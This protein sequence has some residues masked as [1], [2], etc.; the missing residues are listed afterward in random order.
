[1]KPMKRAAW[2]FLAALGTVLLPVLPAQG[3]PMPDGA[4][5][6]TMIA[7]ACSD[8]DTPPCH[9]QPAHGTPACVVCCVTC[10]LAVVPD[11]ETMPAPLSLVTQLDH[12][13]EKGLARTEPPPLPPP[14][15][16]G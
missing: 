9:E 5:C 15:P 7:N 11:I 10:C 1:M 13:A 8:A 3:M 6:G 4:S 12:L 2:L 14:R 16:V